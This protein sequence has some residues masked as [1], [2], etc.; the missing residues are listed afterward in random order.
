MPCYN[1]G[2]YIVE[3]VDSLFAQTYKNIELII[4]DDGSND[5]HTISIL[6]KLETK[7]NI[8]LIHTDHVGPA[9]ARNT[10]ILVSTGRYILPLDSDDL[11]EPE[12]I[13]EAVKVIASDEKVGV[14]Y[15]QADL[16]GEQTGP[17]NLPEYSLKSMLQDNI[18][19]VTSLFYKEDWEKAGGFCTELR[20]GMEDYDFWLSILG[21]GK[22]IVQIP[23][24]LFHYRI[25]PQSRTS[26]FQDNTE[27][28]VETY[29]LLYNRHQALY[30]KHRELYD[31][32]MRETMISLINQRKALQEEVERLKSIADSTPVWRRTINKFLYRKK[33]SV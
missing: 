16:F 26:G 10:G 8:R 12:Y 18:V 17:W 32:A 33:R 31:L 3:S 1:D 5:T 27:Q 11:I 21:M 2:K 28:I 6:K 24:T 30:D 29:S 23:K 13:A 9:A 20:L 19:F 15:C 14:V 7:P 4:I 25:K 22:E